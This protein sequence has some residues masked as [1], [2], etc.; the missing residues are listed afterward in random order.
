MALRVLSTRYVPGRSELAAPRPSR[1]KKS[2]ASTNTRPSLS[3]ATVKPQSTERAKESS[4][5]RRSAGLGLDERNDWLGCTRNTLGPARWKETM[6]SSP[7]WPD[8]NSAVERKR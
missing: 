8:R 1:R 6:R 2:V 3:A 4:T 7:G 5:E